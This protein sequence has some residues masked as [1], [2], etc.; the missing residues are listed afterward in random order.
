MWCDGNGFLHL[1]NSYLTMFPNVPLLSLLPT[2]GPLCDL[3]PLNS[4]T[5][6]CSMY[7]L[8]HVLFKA[9]CTAGILTA[10]NSL[11]YQGKGAASSRHEVPGSQYPTR[12]VLCQHSPSPTTDHCP[13]DH[14]SHPLGTKAKFF[15]CFHAKPETCYRLSLSPSGKSHP[16]HPCSSY[17]SISKPT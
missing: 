7:T 11:L 9:L 2:S 13:L 5:L 15:Q 1:E 14:P 6:R 8:F 10:C 3:C 16:N 4:S 12:C 17:I